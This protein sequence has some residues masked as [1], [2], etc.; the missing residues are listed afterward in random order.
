MQFNKS[1]KIKN[2]SRAS[3]VG[4]QYVHREILGMRLYDFIYMH[5]CLVS[6]CR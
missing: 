4:S 6:A 1:D 2:N 3:L 5:V